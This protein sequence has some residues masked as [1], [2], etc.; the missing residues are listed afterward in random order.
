MTPALD[1]LLDRLH[2][3]AL[4]MRVRFRGI[5]TRE[6]ALIEGP[7]GWGEFGAFVEYPAPEAS[8]WLASGIEAAY[9]ESPTA[10]TVA[11]MGMRSR[12][13]TGGDS[14]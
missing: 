1:D 8:A 12:R 10:G 3:V 2:V 14:R 4:P 5:T 9:L 11:L 6:L 7:T 13:R